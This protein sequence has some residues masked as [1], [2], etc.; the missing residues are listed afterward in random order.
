[1]DPE[2][3]VNK[4]ARTKKA[5]KQLEDRKQR[6]NNNPKTLP[7]YT[8]EE[9]R[10]WII[11]KIMNEGYW[12]FQPKVVA[13]LFQV[14]KENIYND[15]QAIKHHIDIVDADTTKFECGRILK[16]ISRIVMRKLN[17]ERLTDPAIKSYCDLGL[18]VVE[19]QAKFLEDF[20]ALDS[21][22]RTNTSDVT[23]EDFY[24]AYDAVRKTSAQ[25]QDVAVQLHEQ[26]SDKNL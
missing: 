21:E 15:V 1:M 23:W 10:E 22:G 13:A 8:A 26:S 25:V 19:Q 3:T 2:T 11:E 5:K 17:D 20:G 9:R 18:R 16:K 7:E 12:N 4:T 24:T 14:R 6:V